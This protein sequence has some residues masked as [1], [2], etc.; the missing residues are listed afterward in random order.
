MELFG[1]GGRNGQMQA[2]CST[3]YGPVTT[4]G[5]ANQW[6]VAGYEWEPYP[7]YGGSSTNTN[8]FYLDG[9]K[10]WDNNIDNCTSSAPCNQQAQ[11]L[12]IG[13]G[14]NFPANLPSSNG[15]QV[16]WMRIYTHP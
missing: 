16:D 14:L 8:S 13:N 4:G 7:N 1:G 2:D 6:H 12:I 15:M 9:V 11:A 5:I 3:Y 10:G